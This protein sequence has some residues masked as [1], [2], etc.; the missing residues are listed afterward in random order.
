M[1]HKEIINAKFHK[2]LGKCK[3]KPQYYATSQR[4]ACHIVKKLGCSS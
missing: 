2:L 4:D 1:A 3:L